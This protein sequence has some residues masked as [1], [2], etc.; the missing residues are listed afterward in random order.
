MN[1]TNENKGGF[2][3]G[4]GRAF[5]WFLIIYVVVSVYCWLVKKITALEIALRPE[6]RANPNLVW[7]PFI[8]AIAPFALILG[9]A[10]AYD[11]SDN[12]NPPPP[13][14]PTAQAEAP[15]GS[16]SV[17]VIFPVPVSD[18]ALYTYRY[19]FG[20]PDVKVLSATRHDEKTVQLVFVNPYHV[21]DL[22]LTVSGVKDSSGTPLTDSELNSISLASR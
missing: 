7:T 2:L 22:T 5:W 21:Q 14:P 17:T 11:P 9:L 1:D 20:Y 15:Y 3:A 16:L 19:S 13:P 18:T 4:L 12:R 8:A 10:I 6:A